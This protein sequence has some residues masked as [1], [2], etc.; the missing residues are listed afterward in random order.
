MVDRTEQPH[1]A[2]RAAILTALT[3]PGAASVAV[4]IAYADDG[5]SVTYVSGAN[6]ALYVTAAKLAE[7]VAQSAPPRGWGRLG[8]T[9]AWVWTD[10]DGQGAR[11]HLAVQN[12]LGDE[13]DA[14]HFPFADY[15]GDAHDFGDCVTVIIRPPPPLPID[16]ADAEDAA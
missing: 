4:A 12:A 10:I 9:P 11:W 1:G 15:T 5:G 16:P 6:A 3:Q 8:N 13:P 2:G 14:L 7:E